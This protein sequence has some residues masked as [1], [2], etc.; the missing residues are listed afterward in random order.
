MLKLKNN[1]APPKGF[2]YVYLEYIFCDN[3]KLC[4]VYPGRT[5]TSVD[6]RIGKRLSDSFLESTNKYN[7]P[8]HKLT[9]MMGASNIETEIIGVVRNDFAAHLE[10]LLIQTYKNIS[11]N[12]SNT[13]KTSINLDNLIPPK[14]LLRTH[15][16]TQKPID[17]FIS[18]QEAVDQCGVDPYEVNEAI[19]NHTI[20]EQSY[21]VWSDEYV[22]PENIDELYPV[23]KK[24]ECV[25]IKNR[26]ENL[27][28]SGRTIS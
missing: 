7:N 20:Y 13:Q 21:W 2:S 14:I 12:I 5:E 4:F 18:V 26:I 23:S 15:F 3:G 25:P 10:H 27:I 24:R 11:V 28:Q 1:E 22:P 19:A 8:I 9:R 16:E 17:S 6:C